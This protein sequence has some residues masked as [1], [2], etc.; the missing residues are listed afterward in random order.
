MFWLQLLGR[1]SPQ[2]PRRGAELA[3]LAG[4]LFSTGVW[5]VEYININI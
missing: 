4:E 1:L 2:P 5:L 3:M